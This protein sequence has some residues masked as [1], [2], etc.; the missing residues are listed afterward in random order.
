MEEVAVASAF[1]TFAV[2]GFIELVTRLFKKD[3]EAAVKITGAAAIG[4]AAG[5]FVVDGLTVTTGLVAGLAASGIMNIVQRVGTGSNP[6]P[7]D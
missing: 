2:A 4:A 7:V 6:N 5:Y 1:V 3:W